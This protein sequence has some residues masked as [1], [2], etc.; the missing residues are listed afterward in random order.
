MRSYGKPRSQSRRSNENRAFAKREF[1]S[2]GNRIGNS[3]SQVLGSGRMGDLKKNQKIV[4][5]QQHGMDG[6]EPHG[7]GQVQVKAGPGVHQ[8][9][10]P[11]GS[12]EPFIPFTTQAVARALRGQWSDADLAKRD[13]SK[14]ASALLAESDGE[15][16]EEG[17]MSE[18]TEAE[19]ALLGEE[20]QEAYWSEQKVAEEALEAIKAQKATL[21]EARWKQRQLRLG[22]NFFPP[23]PFQKSRTSSQ[24]NRD[25]GQAQHTA[26]YTDP[27]VRR[28][29]DCLCMCEAWSMLVKEMTKEVEES[30]HV[31]EGIEVPEGEETEEEK[32]EREEIRRK[33]QHIHNST[34]HGSMKNL[35]D[36]LEKRGSHEKVIQEAKKWKCSI[37]DARKKMDPRRFATLEAVPKKGERLQIDIATW[38]SQKTKTK[39]FIMMIIDEGSRFRVTRV[40]A[41]G[42][43]NTVNWEMMKKILEE[44]WFAIFGYPKVLR[45]DPAGP[46]ISQ[47]A[48]AYAEDKHFEILPIPAEAHYQIG[49]VEGAIKTMKGILTRLETEFPRMKIEEL[50]SRAT[51]T[52]NNMEMVRGFSPIQRLLGRAPDNAGRIFDSPEEV[53]I[54]P[55]M[56]KDGGLSEDEKMRAEAEKAFLEEQAKRRTERALRMGRRRSEVYL[57]GDLV[58]YWR[59]QVPLG[60]KTLQNSGKFLGPARVIA[61]E[62]RRE[63]SGE[64]RTEEEDSSRQL[65]NSSGKHPLMKPRSMLFKVQSNFHGQSQHWPPMARSNAIK[66]SA[67]RDHQINNGRRQ[68][69]IE[70]RRRSGRSHKED[71][72]RKEIR[73]TREVQVM[74][75][76]E[77]RQRLQ[78]QAAVE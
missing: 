71:S 58:F 54:C 21:R 51:W 41:S 1:K 59:R 61:T 24:G 14:T 69:K 15:Q 13:R 29:V 19:L 18:I 75:A 77:N 25:D 70:K 50:V 66:T 9:M 57:P 26:R 63:P 12:G 40:A 39:Y 32:K 73:E 36:A 67:L 31:A 49:I 34:G 11:L 42:K 38:M 4:R 43:G 76:W 72:G 8:S 33:I 74:L 46:W 68:K 6:R 37:C 45:V 78:Q 28:V 52:S 44:S 20:E 7:H 55:E 16:N 60:E 65:Q 35:V 64:L 22:R 62:T 3:G 23:K 53:P 48:D 47:S 27:F 10:S 30:V 2:P 17:L 5:V 56:L